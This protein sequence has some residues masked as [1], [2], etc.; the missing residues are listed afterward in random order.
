MIYAR[1]EGKFGKY[2]GI[3]NVSTTPNG[4]IDKTTGP[5]LAIPLGSIAAQ[6]INLV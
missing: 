4:K 2:D 3:L 1:N 6:R 5:A